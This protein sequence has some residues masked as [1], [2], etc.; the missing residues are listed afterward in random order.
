MAACSGA[1][2]TGG[3]IGSSVYGRTWAK[4]REDAFTAEVAAS[5]LA[6]RPYDLR[7][8]CISTWLNAGVEA[9]R[10]AEWAGHSVHAVTAVASPR[11][12]SPCR[13]P[14]SAQGCAG[15]GDRV[16]IVRTGAS[17]ETVLRQLRDALGDS[18]T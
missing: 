13:S 15:E 7:H 1:N 5:P 11:A 18:T 8:A 16:G 2:G 9:P 14:S 6:K 12:R 3:R 17:P 10:V 4:A